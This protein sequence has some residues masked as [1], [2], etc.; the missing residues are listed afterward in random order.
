MILLVP[1]APPAISAA[2]DDASALAMA[3]M[4]LSASRDDLR[5]ASMAA[6]PAIKTDR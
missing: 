3:M 1:A 2:Y 4:M 5:R 6:L